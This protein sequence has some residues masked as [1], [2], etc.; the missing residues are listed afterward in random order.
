MIL[1]Y[2]AGLINDI[3]DIADANGDGYIDN[4]DATLILK[5]DAGLIG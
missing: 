2:D 3:S 1:K 5:Y 4:L